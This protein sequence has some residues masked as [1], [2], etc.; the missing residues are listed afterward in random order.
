MVMNYSDVKGKYL[1]PYNVLPLTTEFTEIDW[2]KANHLHEVE[3]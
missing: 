2:L 3:E 1:D